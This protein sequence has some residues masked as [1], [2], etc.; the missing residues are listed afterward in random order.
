MSSRLFP[1]ALAALVALA[2][3][4]EARAQDQSAVQK[5]I[6]L[7]RQA[8]AAFGAKDF[9]GA[10]SALM[11]AVVLGKEAGLTNDKMMAR[12]YLH[13]GVV[14]VDGLKDRAKGLRYLALALRIRP[15]I[16]MTP[17][18]ATPTVTAAFEEAKRDPQ[19]A[20]AG[21]AAPAPKAAPAPA[22]KPA[23]PAPKPAPP[24]PPVVKAAPP[25]PPPPAPEP[26]PA[27]EPEPAA[28]AKDDEPDLP[29]NLP[30]PLYC[31]N[32]DEA[33]PGEAITLR[34]VANPTIV[35]AKVLLYYRLPG[36]ENFSQVPAEKSKKGW[37]IGTIPSDAATGKSLQY[38]FEARDKSAKEVA[39]NGH[40]DSPN[41]MLIKQGAPVV[42]KGALAGLRFATGDK[43]NGPEE[44]PLEAQETERLRAA[45]GL[46]KNRR[47]AKAIF[48]GFSV[49]TGYGY[50]PASRLEY[51]T[52]LQIA[53]GLSS[54]GVMHFAP[55]IGYMITEA[56]SVS[57]QGRFQ[58]I[59]EEG[60]AQA[61]TGAPAHGANS[62]LAKLTYGFGL[63]NG[64]VTASLAAGGGEGYRLQ[65]PPK[66]TNDSKTSLPRND[67][68]RAGPFIV[69]PGIGFLYHFHPAFGWV[70]DAKALIGMPDKGYAA[71][72]STG[73]QVAF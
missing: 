14:Y 58:Y 33:P 24:P 65:V 64:Q 4:E 45:S 20:S 29:A 7:N 18:L 55:E 6:D 22:P 73:P 56:F 9:E 17:S 39:S 32:P 31:P 71:E 8:L 47:R 16:P 27:P 42:G 69:A 49:G 40:N 53:A 35:V 41:L 13:L 48:V 51:R 28:E 60:R 67:T 11:D 68:V 25:P 52:D 23:P 43:G 37:Y 62:V 1:L 10:K 36:G 21:T 38:Y 44:N 59:P 19:G 15:D 46:G 66:P 2:P 72:I 63:G 30:T 3:V 5:M 70:V 26:A 54:V 61:N 50:H 57:L 34:C 12:T